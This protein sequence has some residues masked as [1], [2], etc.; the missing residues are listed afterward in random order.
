MGDDALRVSGEERRKD[1]RRGEVGND[2][3]GAGYFHCREERNVVAIDR[4]MRARISG[5]LCADSF[6]IF[7]RSVPMNEA[8]M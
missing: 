2:D 3:S 1:K 6:I 7:V 4:P 5:S 8:P